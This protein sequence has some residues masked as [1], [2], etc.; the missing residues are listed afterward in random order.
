LRTTLVPTLV[1]IR[2]GIVVTPV[3]PIAGV[4][5]VGRVVAVVVRGVPVRGIVPVVEEEADA[6]APV[7]P[8]VRVITVGPVV[9]V[10]PGVTVIGIVAVAIG[11][12]AASITRARLAALGIRES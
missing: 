1:A 12:G 3:L 8:P 2:V 4:R 9:R 6:E 5:P 10:I 11:A 7:T